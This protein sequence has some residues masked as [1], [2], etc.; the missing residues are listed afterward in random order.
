[1]INVIFLSGY[2]AQYLAMNAPISRYG[3]SNFYIL[4]YPC[5]QFGLQE[6]GHNDEI[7]KGLKYVR[8]GNCYEPKF[9]MMAKVDV[10]G[11]DEIPLYTH[12][13]VG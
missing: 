12:L 8:P 9:H 10:N 13:K 11:P 2:T 3:A 4:G 6:P 1:M 7:L 5:N